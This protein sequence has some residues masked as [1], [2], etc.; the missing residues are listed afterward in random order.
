M[1]RIVTL[2]ITAASLG[3]AS[4]TFAQQGD[5]RKVVPPAPQKPA[6]SPTLTVV[7]P[8]TVQTPSQNAIAVSPRELSTPQPSKPGVSQPAPVETNT[9]QTPNLNQPLPISSVQSSS[10]DKSNATPASAWEAT[11]NA[12]TPAVKA[13]S[14]P[15]QSPPSQN[16]NTAPPLGSSGT[17]T[18]WK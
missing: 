18:E 12:L 3:F 4:P 8:S 1:K 16:W 2:A 5:P 6:V 10:W 9:V 13:S 7:E 17:K 15:W 11:T 14:D